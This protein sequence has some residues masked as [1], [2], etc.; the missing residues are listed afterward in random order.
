[1]SCRGMYRTSATGTRAM[2]PLMMS[3]ISSMREIMDYHTCM[4]SVGCIHDY[5]ALGHRKC[6]VR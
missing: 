2:V 3:D 1:M 6:T 4:H 5:S